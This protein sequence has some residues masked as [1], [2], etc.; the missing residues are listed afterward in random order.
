MT[1]KRRSI[2]KLFSRS[3]IGM[4]LPGKYY[5][6]T[7][8]T[9]LES[10]NLGISISKLQRYLRKIRPGCS[11]IYSLT[12]E[13]NGVC[14]M[15][16]RIPLHLK[17]IAIKE[18]N[19]FWQETH[20]AFCFVSKVKNPKGLANYISDQ[21]QR[22]WMGNEMASQ[23]LTVKWHA[24]SKWFP[25]GFAKQFGKFWFE[26]GNTLDDLTRDEL[27]RDWIIASQNDNSKVLSLPVMIGDTIKWSGEQ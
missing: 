4:L 19:A 21:R 10:P 8:T 13:G 15:I 7:F 2:G 18:M 27:V 5:F 11:W 17:R 9:S 1:L 12:I 25:E 22:K 26:L 6:W 20:K 14:H 23:E 16:L 3:Y 24:S